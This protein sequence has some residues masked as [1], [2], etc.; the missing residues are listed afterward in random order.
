[1]WCFSVL[2]I[3]SRR[4]YDDCVFSIWTNRRR[5]ISDQFFPCPPDPLLP[6]PCL[7]LYIK[8]EESSLH[9]LSPERR[10]ADDLPREPCNVQVSLPR[11][12][13][14][15]RRS[16]RPLRELRRQTHFE[17]HK[18]IRENLCWCN[19]FCICNSTYC[20]HEQQLVGS[21]A[22]DTLPKHS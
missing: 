15:L 2:F 18:F 10:P 8:D 13:P 11:Y 14:S 20:P 9:A 19:S 1:M 16:S 4:Q 17:K 7:L 12:A 6:L 5:K 21:V 22:T 3:T